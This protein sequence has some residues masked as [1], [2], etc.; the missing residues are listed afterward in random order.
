MSTTKTTLTARTV[1]SLPTVVCASIDMDI[2]LIEAVMC[3]WCLLR[4]RRNVQLLRRNWQLQ[5]IGGAGVEIR[6]HDTHHLAEGWPGS[7][8]MQPALPEHAAHI[9]RT[10]FRRD[11]GT[12][13]MPQ[14]GLSTQGSSHCSLPNHAPAVMGDMLQ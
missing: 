4:V 5:H 1:T 12:P 2:V 8:V 3:M 9:R 11:V 6:R 10:H 13:A 7:S 14:H